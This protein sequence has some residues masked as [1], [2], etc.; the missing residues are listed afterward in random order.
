[1]CLCVII[2]KII[3]H[4]DIEA[5]EH[6]AAR[7]GSIESLKSLLENGANIEATDI[8]GQTPLHA[9]SKSG[10]IES[11]KFLLEKGANIE[12]MGILSQTPL[13]AAS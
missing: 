1:M 11:L 13:H 2:Y 3:Y 7:S 5:M 9:A 8:L 12:A 10:K 4:N 6:L